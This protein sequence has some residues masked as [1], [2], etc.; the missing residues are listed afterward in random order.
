M[1]KLYLRKHAEANAIERWKSLSNLQTEIEKRSKEKL[2]KQTEAVS[3]L[4]AASASGGSST[5]GSGIG[6]QT[7]KM[8]KNKRRKV[9][10]AA[11][12][13]NMKGGGGGAQ[14]PE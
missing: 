5:R 14:R 11:I 7:E 10:M 6:E 13:A 4:F 2:D 1:M 12:V 3:G 8:T 9:N